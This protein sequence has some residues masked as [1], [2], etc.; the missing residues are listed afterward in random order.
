MQ[1]L[2]ET[3]SDKLQTLEPVIFVRLELVAG[4]MFALISAREIAVTGA[5]LMVMQ[6]GK[7]L[8]AEKAG[9]LKTV[10]QMAAIFTILASLMFREAG[11]T[12]W[13][14]ERSWH[15]GIDALMLC[16]VGLTLFS[17]V[18]YFWNNRRAFRPAAG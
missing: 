18:T 11:I 13:W 14:L 4:W 15:S 3:R 6:R 1:I 9:K 16:T 5:R 7:V 2:A 17:G 8:A 12:P 10:S